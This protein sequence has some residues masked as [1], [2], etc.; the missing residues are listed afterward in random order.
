MCA[1]CT[2]YELYED[3]EDM[4]RMIATARKESYPITEKHLQELEAMVIQLT[5]LAL[6]KF[7]VKPLALAMGI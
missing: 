2:Q 1:I 7:G 3:L 4:R 5:K 6:P